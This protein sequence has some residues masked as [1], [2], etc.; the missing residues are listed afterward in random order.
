VEASGARVILAQ[1][2]RRD[3]AVLFTARVTLVAMDMQGRARRIPA[4]LL[5]SAEPSPA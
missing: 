5:E 1:E 3:D 2:V 4:R